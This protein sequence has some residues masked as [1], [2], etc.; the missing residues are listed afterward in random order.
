MGM[1]AAELV[2]NSLATVVAGTV[3]GVSQPLLALEFE[4][5]VTLGISH[6][7][8]VFL[9]AEDGQHETIYRVE[10]G[11]SLARTSDR[12]DLNVEYLLQ[13]FYYDQ[14]GENEVF[15]QYAASAE[16]SLLPEV[17]FLEAGGS[18][19]QA[20]VS[21]AAKIPQSNL[22]LTSNRTDR[23]AYYIGTGFNY[24]LGSEVAV[25]G[26]YR[27]TWIDYGDFDREPSTF[28]RD[29]TDES[30]DFS[31][32]NYR[33]AVGV[34]WALRY[35][36]QRSIYENDLPPWVYQKAWAELGFWIS[37]TTR[38]FA[39]GGRE[40]S[41]DEPAD[42]SMQDKF[43][44]AG[45]AVSGDRLSVEFAAGERTFGESWRGNL[46]LTNR[47]G[48]VFLNYTQAPTT[49][50]RNPYRPGS[51]LP[52]NPEDDDNWLSRPGSAER[53]VSNRF[54]FG[55]ILDLRRTTVSLR[56]FDEERTDRTTAT[57]ES[58]DNESQRGVNLSVNYQLGS[59][60]MFEGVASVV[61]RQL[62]EFDEF[63][64][65]GD[66]RDSSLTRALAGIEYQLGS[67]T[68][69]TLRYDY[70]SEDGNSALSDYAANTVSLLLT[71]TF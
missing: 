33:R 68:S 69:V 18:R 7:D 5:R 54:T 40:S 32:D 9:T 11:L 51:Q 41:W 59:K 66:G 47:L 3:F 19:G 39:S 14:L 24:V 42:S 44:E 64:E 48:F 34:T 61:D 10:P 49:E 21:P 60:T 70:A 4:P 63:D 22:P 2:S 67:K 55:W 15:H 29:S 52:A 20:I 31:I 71:R 45:F 35:D 57:G 46:Q 36:W 13:A 37:S 58:L 6:T 25:D 38:L 30:A 50:N 17:L 12:I 16:V 23:D 27:H 8:N 65:F 56:V 43:W 1:K 62:G 26:G 28:V 53:F